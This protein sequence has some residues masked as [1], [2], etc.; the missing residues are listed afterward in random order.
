VDRSKQRTNHAVADLL[1][2]GAC[3]FLG[4]GLMCLLWAGGW[5]T[6]ALGVL[7]LVASMIIRRIWSGLACTDRGARPGHPATCRRATRSPS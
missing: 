4:A 3:I 7:L 1:L 5:H 2:A 6:A